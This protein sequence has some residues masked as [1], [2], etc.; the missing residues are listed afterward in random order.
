V[1]QVVGQMN[2]IHASVEKSDQMIKSLY[3]RS[4]EIGSIS[5]V[6]SGISQQTN[7]LALNAAIEAARAGEHGKGFAVVATEVRLLAEQSQESAKQ[8][9]ELIAEIQKET[10]ASV[11]NMEKVRQD[12]AEGLALSTETI[13]K[14]EEIVQSTRQTNPLIDEVSAIAGQIANAVHEVTTAANDLA[15]I[16]RGNAETAEEV[17]ASSEEQL[18]SMEEISSSAQALS[19]LSEE[20]KVLINKFTYE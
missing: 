18:A 15:Q 6:I 20:L 3:D 10:R 13:H 5:E 16:A 2:S 8:I 14:F 12:V 1:Q 7:L 17:A 9:V 19:M 11:D 4:K